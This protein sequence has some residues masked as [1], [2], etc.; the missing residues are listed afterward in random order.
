MEK[1]TFRQKVDGFFKFL[2]NSEKKEV[3]G[4]TG[5]SWAEIGAFYLVFYTVLA[6]FFAATIA[7]FY[8]TIDDDYPKLQGDSSLLKANPGMG[9]G[10]MPDIETTL[11]HVTKEGRKSYVDHIN[12]MLADYN[13]TNLDNTDCSR[14]NSTRPNEPISCEVNFK[15]LTKNCN[16]ENGYGFLDGKPC[17]LLKLN[18]IFG[19]EPQV[20]TPAEAQGVR[21]IPDAIKHH[22]TDDRIWIDCHGENPADNDNLG[23]LEYSP[24]QGFP[25]AFYPF[26]NQKDYRSPLVFVKFNNFTSHLGFM[27][28]CK[29]LAKN[30][31]VDRAEKE[32]SVHFELLIDV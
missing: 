28:E 22:Y 6:A 25:K 26:K 20:W 18:R 11:I 29:A 15:E 19:W 17:I 9:Y 14:I 24:Q 2:W 16:E 27:I 30:I 31:E 23:P 32:G 1:L 5:R 4:R 13:Q 21:A 12:K 7:G 10:P 3:L 8:Q